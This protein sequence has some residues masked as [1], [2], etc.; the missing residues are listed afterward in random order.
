MANE[1]PVNISI[2]SPGI[3]NTTN[4]FRELRKQALQLRG[5]LTTLKRGSEEYNVVLE[6]LGNTQTK[7][8][9]IN[10]DATAAS[11]DNVQQIRYLTQAASG[12][13]AGFNIYNS[14]AALTGVENENL[15]N[16]FVKLQAG[17]SILQ[18]INSFGQSIQAL[19]L[20]F[21]GLNTTL[22]TSIGL[23]AAF[24]IITT[25]GTWIANLNDRTSELENTQREFNEQL[26]RS[27]TEYQLNRNVIQGLTDDIDE[28]I[29][30]DIE[31]TNI[32][33]ENTI[34]RINAINSEIQALITQR[35]AREA[36]GIGGLFSEINSNKEIKALRNQLEETQ[37]IYLEL[38][39]KLTELQQ[40]RAARALASLRSRNEAE[41]RAQQAAY[42]EQLRRQQ[43]FLNALEN[44]SFN[45][46]ARFQNWLYNTRQ[47]Y[48][49]ELNEF[50]DEIISSFDSS[51]FEDKFQ[52]FFNVLTG[53]DNQEQNSIFEPFEKWSSQEEIELRNQAY[54][55]EI[56]NLTNLYIAAYQSGEDTQDI[57]TRLTNAR[58][59]YEQFQNVQDAQ[60]IRAIQNEVN[61]RVAAAR[62][63]GQTFVTIGNEL[64]SATALQKS[65]AAT[66]AVINTFAAAYQVL[67]NPL[68][69]NPIVKW[70]QFAAVVS[71]GLA[72]LYNITSQKIPGESSSESS[73]TV[74]AQLPEVPDINNIE[75]NYN[76][77]NGFEEDTI[78]VVPQRVYLVESDLM[79]SINKL[80]R[81][82]NETTF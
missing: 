23:F 78:N 49:R 74:N 18:S 63:I 21:R 62:A 37:S 76:Y 11:A 72:N 6:K 30:R 53:Q 5:E 44:Q 33:I 19:N 41:L 10:R 52:E 61:A 38:S 64:S 2:E 17:M 15:A 25:V 46:D 57:Y 28:L 20:I 26:N 56:E 79:Q 32:Q 35:N 12:L 69:I 31:Y 42:N 9:Q 71:G 39:D 22:Q 77:T 81:L 70:A 73:P 3:K 65:I 4:S 48:I 40:Q 47:R 68:T 8:T 58:R 36:T 67:A 66:G 34:D 1:V 7:I 27:N 45:A 43:R 55:N 54:I 24:A 16:T 80:D 13:V 29:D 75:E 82:E 59:E 50:T 14:I 51:D 60:R